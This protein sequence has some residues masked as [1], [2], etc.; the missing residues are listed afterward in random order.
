MVVGGTSKLVANV[1]VGAFVKRMD[2][3]RPGVEMVVVRNEAA[4]RYWR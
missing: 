4:K 2:V 1:I 3:A